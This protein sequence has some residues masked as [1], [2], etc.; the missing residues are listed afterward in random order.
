MNTDPRRHRSRPRRLDHRPAARR[1]RPPGA[2]ADPVGQRPGPPAHRAPPRRRV[3]ARR[4]GA[5]PSRAR[6]PSTTASTG[7]RTTPRSGAPSS[8]QA[9]RAVLEA[10]GRV[11][12]VVVFPESLY[13]Y[14]E[15]DGVMTEATPRTASDG[16]AR[17]AHRAAGPA[18][19]VEHA[20]GQ[21]RGVRL[22]RPGGAHLARRRAP[23]AD[24]PGREDDAGRRQ[25]RPAALLHLRPRPG[26]RDDH[27]RWARGPL[28]LLPPRPHRAGPH[29]ARADHEGRADGRRTRAE[30]VVAPGG[31]AERD[32]P[33][34]EQRC[35]RWPRPATCSPSRSSWTPA[36]ASSASDSPPRR[37]A[38]GLAATVAWWRA[39]E[40]QAA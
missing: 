25:P 35:A 13:S 27:R 2:A 39:Q 36:R 10:A 32:G 12:A 16:Q 40:Q 17:R 5:R 9:E 37:M 20:D 38:E 33:G 8:P 23:G 19:C 1:L 34:L 28:E 21:R 14:G 24:G 31:R 6:S 7:R 22:L 26:R 15:V 18:R 3:A 4:A 30:D 11:G 29:P